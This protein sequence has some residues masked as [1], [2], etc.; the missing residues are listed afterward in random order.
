MAGEEPPRRKFDPRMARLRGAHA[1]EINRL[2]RE[3]L[4]LHPTIDPELSDGGGWTDEQDT[5]WRA[6][7]TEECARFA[8]ERDAL[9]AQLRDEHA[10]G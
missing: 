10:D 9:S 2:F 8:R 7:T 5:A 3:F 1:R 4:R 6:F